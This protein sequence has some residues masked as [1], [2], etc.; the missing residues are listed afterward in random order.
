MSRQSRNVEDDVASS[1]YK[2]LSPGTSPPHSPQL[3]SPPTASDEGKF[4]PKTWIKF[5]KQIFCLVGTQLSIKFNGQS[6]GKKIQTFATLFLK[7]T[8]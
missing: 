8:Q 4:L 1:Q 2:N 3:K 6:R 5:F 7:Y